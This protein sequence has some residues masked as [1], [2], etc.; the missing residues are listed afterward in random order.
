MMISFILS[1][2]P[3]E[4]NAD[5]NYGLNRLTYNSINKL[6]GLQSFEEPAS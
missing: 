3:H 5:A 4:L 2:K 6:L 1:S